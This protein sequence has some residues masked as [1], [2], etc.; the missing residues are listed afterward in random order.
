MADKKAPRKFTLQISPNFQLGFDSLRAR[1]L[2][3]SIH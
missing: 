1:L 2:S 3:V